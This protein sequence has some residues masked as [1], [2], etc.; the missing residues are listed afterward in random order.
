MSDHDVKGDT[1]LRGCRVLDL[2]DEKGCLC[3][4][5]LAELGADVIKIE[6]PGGDDAR[7]I[8]PFYQDAPHPE[9]SLWWWFFNTSKRGITLDLQSKDGKVL[10]Q[11]L[12]K[13]ADVIVECMNPGEMER[14]GLGYDEMSKTNK[15]VIMTSITPFGATGPHKDYK[16][17]D[18][19]AL[20]TGG[21]MFQVG[22][23]DRRPVRYGGSQAYVQTGVQA[24][25]GTLIAFYYREL[26]G[27]GQQV[28]VSVQECAA[29]PVGADAL[30]F[31][32]LENFIFPRYG[33]KFMFGNVI[34]ELSYPAKD[35]FIIG[36]LSIMGGGGG[37]ALADW[38]KKEGITE[39]TANVEEDLKLGAL[40][41]Q[42]LTQEVVDKR[43]EWLRNVLPRY[44]VAEFCNQ[45]QKK[46][47]EVVPAV[48]IKD[49]AE[50]D[51]LRERGFYVD[52]EH[53]ELG[54]KITY[55]RIPFK[56][57]EDLYEVSRRAPLIGEHNEEI[58]LG[59][60]GLTEEE[61]FRLKEAGII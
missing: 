44:S 21:P 59:E 22:D 16:T 49:I 60:I 3:A 55:P 54:R 31:W 47:I 28:D 20:A 57:S 8:G 53:P 35:G 50:D 6:K 51:S 17:S 58:Y 13:R 39:Y 1:P 15:G 2:A 61:L 45:A 56:S 46:R 25:I 5:I 26:T 11:R 42:G 48:T 37:Q 29:F 4:K 30:M 14:L 52:L 40:R 41:T 34:S 38:M 7:K 19:V 27:E 36:T 23:P 18:L 12:A 32:Q 24:A 33:S 9:R 10:F 43:E